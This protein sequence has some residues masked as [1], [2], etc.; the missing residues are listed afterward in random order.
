MRV[1]LL[2]LSVLAFL[3][4]LS[5]CIRIDFDLCEESRPHED[6]GDGGADASTDGADASPDAAVNDAAADAGD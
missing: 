4:L 2:V 1:R 5:S 3:S 6:C